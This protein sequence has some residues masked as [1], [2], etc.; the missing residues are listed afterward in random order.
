[1]GIQEQTRE[2]ELVNVDGMLYVRT[3]YPMDAEPVVIWNDWD[4]FPRLSMLDWSWGSQEKERV[5]PFKLRRTRYPGV[6]ED[7]RVDIWCRTEYR[8]D[9]S[10][11]C[12]RAGRVEVPCPKVR[13]GTETRWNGMYWQKWNKREGWVAI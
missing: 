1:M 9:P 4:L 11:K 3:Y 12:V 8:I 6:F 10:A 13:V 7:G 2:A 5:C